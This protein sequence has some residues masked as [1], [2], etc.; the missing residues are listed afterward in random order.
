MIDLNAAR[1]T[2]PCRVFHAKAEPESKSD[3]DFAASVVLEWDVN[4]DNLEAA[5]E[6]IPGAGRVYTLATD[7]HN[8]ERFEYIRRPDKALTVQVAGVTGGAEMDWAKLVASKVQQLV[9]V[10][11]RLAGRSLEDVGEL[12]AAWRHGSTEIEYEDKQLEL[13][14]GGANGSLPAE[15]GQPSA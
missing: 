6:L 3:D 13:I 1:G 10:K 12:F 15:A 5:D 7:E 8:K 4:E 14:D 9:R 11:L 2:S